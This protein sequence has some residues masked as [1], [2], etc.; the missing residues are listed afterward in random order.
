MHKS[1]YANKVHMPSLPREQSVI[2][3]IA[4]LNPGSAVIQSGKNTEIQRPEGTPALI[5]HGISPYSIG[6]QAYPMFC[7]YRPQIQILSDIY[8]TNK[9]W[10]LLSQGYRQYSTARYRIAI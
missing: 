1:V 5:L 10:G 4:L 6:I 3:T 8:A 9:I 2:L 7:N